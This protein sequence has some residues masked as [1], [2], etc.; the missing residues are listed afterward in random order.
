MNQ[1]PKIFLVF[2]LFVN[3]LV[4]I[5]VEHRIWRIRLYP[6]YA[7][8]EHAYILSKYMENKLRSST[9]IRRKDKN[10][11]GIYAYSPNTQEGY[12]HILLLLISVLS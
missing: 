3:R 9:C 8:A 4:N 11:E 1:E 6:F 12:V 2:D 5:N 10:A 7:L